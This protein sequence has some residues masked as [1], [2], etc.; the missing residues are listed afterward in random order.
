MLTK[1][2]VPLQSA[3]RCRVQ[4]SVAGAIPTYGSPPRRWDAVTTYW[5]ND[6]RKNNNRKTRP[7][8]GQ[9][10]AIRC[11]TQIACVRSYMC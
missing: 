10:S 1:R 7:L 3:C 9:T 11:H 2:Y 4:N 6:R 8:I 5:R